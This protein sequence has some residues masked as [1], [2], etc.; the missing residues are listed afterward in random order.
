MKM[1]RDMTM[2]HRSILQLL[3][4][5]LLSL[6]P[7]VGPVEM[8]RSAEV[9][10]PKEINTE[11]N[12]VERLII[13]QN[14]GA[15]SPLQTADGIT[16]LG[17]ENDHPTVAAFLLRLLKNEDSSIR[18]GAAEGL[19]GMRGSAKSVTPQLVLLLKD[20]APSVR[21]GAA[22]GL[23][24]ISKSSDSAVPQLIPLLKDAEPSVRRSAASGLGRIGKSAKSAVPQLIPLLEDSDR[25]T[26]C[27]AA[28]TLG[29][30]G[31][32]AK[33][34]LRP[35]IRLLRDSE[36]DPDIR[37]CTAFALGK[38]E[39]FLKDEENLPVKR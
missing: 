35:L 27:S 23:G 26:R 25:W 9:I 24:M 12:R 19:G 33:V 1:N 21:S 30:I 37:D 18:G 5:L 4:I 39:P 3:P 2:M 8:A 16:R 29:L 22:L 34:A 10:A 28:Q 32:P 38:I 17:R 20:P 31:E 7:V 6:F 11:I 13:L 15:I 36:S 14:E